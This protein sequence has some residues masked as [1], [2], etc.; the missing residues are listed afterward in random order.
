VPDT[1]NHRKTPLQHSQLPIRQTARKTQDR[2]TWAIAKF[3][4]Y[5]DRD[6]DITLAYLID[7]STGIWFFNQK[8]SVSGQL[9]RFEVYCYRHCDAIKKKKRWDLS[10]TSR[11]IILHL[12]FQ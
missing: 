3:I 6:H 4:D 7:A 11:D 5:K 9:D 1:Q 2:S 12:S 10:P 8:F